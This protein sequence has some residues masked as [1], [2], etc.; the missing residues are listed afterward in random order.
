LTVRIQGTDLDVI[1]LEL[2]LW[3]AAEITVSASGVGDERHVLA[4]VKAETAEDARR[5]VKEALP[6]GDFTLGH[7]VEVD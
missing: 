3:T 4:H 7:V 6:D 2:P 1:D 5:L